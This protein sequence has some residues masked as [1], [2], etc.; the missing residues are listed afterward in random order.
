M[1]SSKS[2]QN[3]MVACVEKR[4]PTARAEPLKARMTRYAAAHEDARRGEGAGG[5]HH[6]ARADLDAVP[7]RPR[8]SP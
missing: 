3:V 6:A 4:S 1:G 5:Q 8:A 2:E 7:G